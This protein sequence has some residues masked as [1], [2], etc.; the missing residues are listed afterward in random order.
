MSVL[1]TKESCVGSQA[2][3]PALGD[4]SPTCALSRCQPHPTVLL[5]RY[6]HSPSLSTESSW[7]S[8]TCFKCWAKS[9]G[10]H[11]PCAQGLKAPETKKWTY[12][13]QVYKTII[14]FSI[15]D[16]P[17]GLV[18]I[19]ALSSTIKQCSACLQV[20]WSSNIDA[21]RP[22]QLLGMK[23]SVQFS[24]WQAS[25][26]LSSFKNVE[27]YFHVFIKSVAK[28]QILDVPPPEYREPTS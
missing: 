12:T 27:N 22:L 13:A 8:L 15:N 11:S 24:A 4:D 28:V 23:M 25:L 2:E 21:R 9:S 18:S 1:S 10:F 7:V 6:P 16:F 20:I 5:L 3:F 17:T 14:S 19:R 26:I